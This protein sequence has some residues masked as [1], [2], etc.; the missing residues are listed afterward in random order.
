MKYKSC[1]L[2]NAAFCR[3]AREKVLN[4]F[5]SKIF[6]TKN[7][8]KILT[9]EQSPEQAPKLTLFDVSEPTKTQN[10]KSS[11]TFYRYFLDKI[12]NYEPNVKN[13]IFNEYFKHY[14]PAYLIKNHISPIK[15]EMRK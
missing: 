13:E 10:R 7:Q 9:S 6:P 12:A 11:S 15:L 8:D 5:R 4:N 2:I 3:D 14:N 1:F